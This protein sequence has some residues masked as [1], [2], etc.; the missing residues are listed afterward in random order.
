[1]CFRR[2]P[3]ARNHLKPDSFRQQFNGVYLFAAE[4]SLA[5]AELEGNIRLRQV[6]YIAEVENLIVALRML[7]LDVA[8]ILNRLYQPV[9]QANR[10]GGVGR[11]AE[12]RQQRAVAQAVEIV[13]LRQCPAQGG[14]KLVTSHSRCHGVRFLTDFCPVGVGRVIPLRGRGW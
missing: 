11:R 14:D 2:V 8:Q 13:Q 7:S 6:F 5:D 1:M 3:A 9:L 10:R 12:Q 4:L